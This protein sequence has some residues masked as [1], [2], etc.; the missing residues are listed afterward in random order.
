M[1]LTDTLSWA[2][3]TARP[4]GPGSAMTRREEL[5]FVVFATWTISGL[6]LD[7]WS[8]RM[9]KPETFFTPWHGLLYS[10]F[11]ASVLWGAIDGLRDGAKRRR[12]GQPPR[13][14]V[15]GQALTVLGAAMFALG[16]VGDM[17]WHLA[18]GIEEDIEA[19]VSP[20]HLLLMTGGLLVSTGPL[21]AARAT[22]SLGIRPTL[23]AFWPVVMSAALAGAL[24]LFFTQY[25]NAFL[26][27]DLTMGSETGQ[28]HGLA[29]FLATTTVMLI[30]ALVLLTRWR[31]PPGTFTLYFA[32]TG[33][34]CIGLEAAM[35][36]PLLAVPVAAGV[37]ADIAA[38][39]LRS[40]AGVA[41][42][43]TAVMW[44]AFFAMFAATRGVDWTADMWTGAVASS[45]ALAIGLG[46][47]AG[48]RP[49]A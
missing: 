1:T 7:G 36:W 26:L 4:P 27:E 13:P 19:L 15:A 11:A 28:A 2:R 40:T 5:T 47:L 41:A 17:S 12:D 32:I 14:P 44:T 35:A 33:G 22:G 3:T 48:P 38:A 42:A 18:F 34:L 46:I 43:T 45:I 10:G 29:S 8:H 49:A 25:L 16:G 20:T 30:P 6:F 9:D 37:A 39:R 31:T 23:S 24:G 21:R